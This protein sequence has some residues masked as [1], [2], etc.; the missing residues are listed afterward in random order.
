M[1]EKPVVR[2]KNKPK[3]SQAAGSIDRRLSYKLFLGGIAAISCAFGALSALLLAATPLK[4]GSH[5]PNSPDNLSGIIPTTL[6]RPINVLVLGIDNS[7]HPHLG[8]YTPAEALAGNS[9]TMLLVR[10]FPDTHQIN[11]LSIPRDTLVQ[12]PGISIDK[13]NDANVR[14]GAKLAAETISHLLS[15]IPIDRYVRLDTEGFAHFIDAL[16]GVEVTI[17]KPMRYVDE[18]QHLYINFKAGRHK[19][20]GQHLQEYVRFR[21]DE[22]GDI[23]RVQ[24]QQVVLKEILHSLLQ[25]STL[26]KLPKMLQVVKDN[27]DTDVSVGEMLAIAQLLAHAD[28]EHLNMVMLPGRF[29]GKNEYHLSYWIKN[30]K[31]LAPILASYFDVPNSRVHNITVSTKSLKSIKPFRIAVINATGRQGEA[32]KALALLKKRGFDNIY[33]STHEVDATTI[34]LMQTQIIA[35]NG[36]LEAAEAVKSAIGVGQ[37]QAASTGDI[38][39]DITVVVGTDLAAKLNK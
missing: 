30:P 11:I 23:G 24:R 16:G 6:T 14:G 33:V 35:Q 17:P 10:L 25:P 3:K 38:W 7:G 28:R 18:S 9:D 22:L 15:D 37:A 20:N 29:S 36:N 4:S 19:L 32:G 34:P 8:N 26:G 31:A 12:M 21:H 2:Q 1:N 39:S 5:L 13:I 27:A